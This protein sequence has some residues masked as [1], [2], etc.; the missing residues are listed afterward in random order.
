MNDIK[1]TEFN[2]DERQQTIVINRLFNAK[3]NLVWEAW[4]NP[5]LLY[6]WRAPKPFVAETKIMDFKNGG[7]WLYAIV[8]PDGNKH[9]SRYDYQLIEPEKKI[10]ENRIFS[11]ENGT[12]KPNIQPSFATITFDEIDGKTQIIETIKYTNTE[13]FQ[14][15]SSD[16]H[17]KGY[18][19]TFKQLDILLNEIKVK[20]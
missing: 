20:L 10:T 14:R 19:S 5:E 12:K 18:S 17:K 13:I 9:W 3:K 6:K 1:T 15:M 4:T 2:I 8:G 7:F 16:N 11:D